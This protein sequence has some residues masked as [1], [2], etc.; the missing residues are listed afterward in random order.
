MPPVTGVTPRDTLEIIALTGRNTVFLT[1]DTSATPLPERL[2]WV[3][4]RK[5]N[6]NEVL[7]KIKCC[8]RT[9]EGTRRTVLRLRCP[10]L[11]KIAGTNQQ[12]ERLNA[13]KGSK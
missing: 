8:R 12:C 2:R 1:R 6:H 9:H 4:A 10:S 11:T 13:I 5:F 7:C 3:N